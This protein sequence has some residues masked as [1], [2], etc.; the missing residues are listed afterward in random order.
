MVHARPPHCGLRHD[1]CEP[2][3]SGLDAQTHCP[4]FAVVALRIAPVFLEPRTALHVVVAVLAGVAVRIAAAVA[5][6]AA[7]PRAVVLITGRQGEA[8]R[9]P[10]GVWSQS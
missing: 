7:A 9:L 3:T 5:A 1:A 2:E 10:E 6:F 4:R 8:S